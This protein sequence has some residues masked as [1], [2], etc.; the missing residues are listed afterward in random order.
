MSQIALLIRIKASTEEVYHQLA[1][2][3]GVAKW[4]AEAAYSTGKATG[5]LKLTLWRETDFIVTENL[6]SS[7][8]VWHCTSKDNP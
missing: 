2:S 4:F 7:R 5:E 3:D 6:P 8:I 1:T